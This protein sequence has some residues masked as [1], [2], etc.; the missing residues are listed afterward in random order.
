MKKKS[1]HAFVAVLDGSKVRTMRT[2]Y[3][4][5]NKLLTFPDYFGRNLDAL[6]DCLCDLE[7]IE[8]PE[9]VLS[10]LHA[11]AFLSK[12]SPEKKESVLNLFRDAEKPENRCDNK[13]F[14]VSFEQ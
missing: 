7:Q 9:V 8:A 6:Y 12:E 2:L 13:Q 5:L 1:E 3:S 14:T 11:D 4:Q 10:V